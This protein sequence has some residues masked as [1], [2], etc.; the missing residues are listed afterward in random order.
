MLV[1]DIAPVAFSE[2][3]ARGDI[4]RQVNGLKGRGHAAEWELESSAA[5]EQ[6][7]AWLCGGRASLC[8]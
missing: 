3:T 4:A 5:A 6:P 1:L 8:L 7:N 2:V